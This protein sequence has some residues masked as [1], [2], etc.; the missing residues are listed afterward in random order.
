[1]LGG[2]EESRLQNLKHDRQEVKHFVSG[3]A[4]D[5]PASE[6][7]EEVRLIFNNVVKPLDQLELTDRL[8]RLGLDYHFHDENNRTL[9]NIHT[10]LQ[11]N[12]IWEKDLH[13][14]ALEFRLL[15]QHGHYISLEGFKRF[16]ENGSFKKGESLME[17]VWSFTTKS[18]GKCLENITDLDL[19]VQVRHALE[20]PLQW[21]VPAF[22]A[23][24]YINLYQKS[25]DMIPSVLEFAKLNFNIRQALYQEELKD[26]SRWWSRLDI[27]KRSFL[28]PEIELI[29]V[30]DDVYDIY[31]TLDEL[32]CFT[33]VVEK[34]EI[35]FIQDRPD[36][37]RLAYEILRLTD[38]Y[39]TTSAELK[40]G[41]VPSSIQCYMS[42]IML[43]L[44]RAAHWLY[45]DG[46]DGYGA[47]DFV[48]KATLVSLLVEPI[49]LQEINQVND[50]MG[51]D[52][53]LFYP[54]LI[55]CSHSH[56]GS[57]P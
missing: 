48:A 39:G 53:R 29:G 49:S 57:V 34:E 55:S 37:V 5:E 40:R 12:E 32:E 4:I 51:K 2:R 36:I 7:K 10:G 25:C 8:Q 15:R 20:L 54:W 11:N 43:N 45:N 13:A 56:P 31:G 3:E 50:S 33:D 47:E 9:K 30:Y 16:T 28:L 17:E 41:D 19:Q 1:M 22:D 46:N 35:E 18:L 52:T 6:L 26:L 21:S 23:R 38:D 14:T 44:V 27:V 24:W 42:D